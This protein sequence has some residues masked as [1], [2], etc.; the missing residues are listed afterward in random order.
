M[1]DQLLALT[2]HRPWEWAIARGFK[3]V[4][5]RGWPPPPQVRGKLIALHAG[6]SYDEDGAQWMADCRDELGVTEA[7]PGPTSPSGVI[8]AIARVV[9]ALRIDVTPHVALGLEPADSARVVASPWAGGPWC[10]LL[11][12]VVQLA[13]PVPCRGAQ[14]LWP[15]PADLLPTLRERYGA[16][17]GA[18]R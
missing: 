14:K 17:R 8:V 6:K 15:V 1:R 16:A 18:S 3:P 5:N 12:D 13:E 11:D 10:W 4:E 9:G 2:L 7:V